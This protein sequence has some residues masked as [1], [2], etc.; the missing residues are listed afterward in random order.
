MSG[1]RTITPISR[2]GVPDCA[3]ARM[4]RAISSAS[5]STVGRRKCHRELNAR[6][7]LS[8]PQNPSRAGRRAS[9][10]DPR[11]GSVSVRSACAPVASITASSG[12]VSARKPSIQIVYD[13][14]QPCCAIRCAASSSRPRAILPR[15]DSSRSTSHTQGAN[16]PRKGARDR[17]PSR[18]ASQPAAE[19]SS[20][21]CATAAQNPVLRAPA[22]T[23]R[24]EP[25]RHLS[26]PAD[27]APAR[28]NP[29]K[30]SD[31]SAMNF[32]SVRIRS[33][34]QD[35]A[36]ASELMARCSAIVA[37]GR[38]AEYPMRSA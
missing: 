5:R 18:L 9:D 33:R 23:R 1:F 8:A 2:K 11:S 27:T 12:S 20:I 19:N 16:G 35:K 10:S 7:L 30:S 25:P 34:P 38:A 13:A 24:S 3:W 32:E 14:R 21:G 26:R 28:R 15:R 29:G 36:F 22:R 6:P 31:H 37:V 4:R 17:A